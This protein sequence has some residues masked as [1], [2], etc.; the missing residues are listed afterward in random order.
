MKTF[1]FEF[2]E[3]GGPHMLQT[4]LNAFEVCML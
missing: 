4:M 3:F 2:L 1:V